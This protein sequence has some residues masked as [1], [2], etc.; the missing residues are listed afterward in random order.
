MPD[1]FHKKYRELNE[2]EK[3][4]MEHIKVTAEELEKSFAMIATPESGR[5]KALANT[6]L[7]ESIMWAIKGLTK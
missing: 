5:E 2:G 1:T 7:E 6:K 4:L 3:T